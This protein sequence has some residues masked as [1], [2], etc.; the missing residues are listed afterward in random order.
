[1]AVGSTK[2]THVGLRI[3][4]R[5]QVAFIAV[6]AAIKRAV[7]AEVV[8]TRG[9]RPALG[10]LTR[11]LLV[12]TVPSRRT[13]QAGSANAARP[14]AKV[15]TARLKLAAGLAVY[16]LAL[17]ADL[18]FRARI[19]RSATTVVAARLVVAF[20]NARTVPVRTYAVARARSRIPPLETA[21]AVVVITHGAKTFVAS[22]SLGF[23]TFMGTRSSRLSQFELS[24]RQISGDVISRDTK[25]HRI[26]ERT[27]D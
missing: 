11:A 21:V 5:L 4:H 13:E 8:A 26:E 23:H 9:R 24:P 17:D 16:A 2:L 12:G 25:V 20:R 14:A 18:P 7:A 6:V 3:F 19:A 10:A 27:V 22:H 1:L 15:Q